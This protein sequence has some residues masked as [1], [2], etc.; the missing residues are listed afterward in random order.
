MFYQNFYRPQVKQDVIINN[1]HG[2]CG[3]PHDLLHL[4]T[5]FSQL[6]GALP[7]QEKKDLG[8]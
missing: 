7:T 4:P 8:S 1:K 2:I 5:A 6:G 3:L